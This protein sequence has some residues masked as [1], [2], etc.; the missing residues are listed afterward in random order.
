MLPNIALKNEN[1]HT[2]NYGLILF[3]CYNLLTIN[4]SAQSTKAG[5]ESN[6]QQLL[7]CWTNVAQPS[8]QVCFQANGRLLF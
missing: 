7:G 6:P 2:A 5:E 4:L 1:S 3:V 8:S